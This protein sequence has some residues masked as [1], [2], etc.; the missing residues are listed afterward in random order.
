[1]H[2]HS[3]GKLAAI[4]ALPEVYQ[5]VGVVEPDA[6]RRKNVSGVKF[7]SEEALLNTQDLQAVAIE[8]R[9]RDLVPTAARVVASGRHI[10]LDKPAGP[11]LSAFRKLVADAR[12]QKLTIQMGYMLRYNPAF[13]FMFRAVREGWFGE[14]M[15]IDAM[16]G[17]FAGPG[18]RQE[19]AEY[20]GGGF[21]ELACH[22]L[23]SAL[24]I[25][26]KP[27]KV[28]GINRRTREGK[29]RGDTFADNQLAV[30]E[31]SKGTACLRCNHND[32]FGGPRRR[33]NIAGTR[34]GME[35]RPLESGKFVLTLDRER[36]KYQKG[37]QTV[38]LKGGRSYEAEF[39]DLARVIRG[40]DPLAWNHEHDLV[41][42]ETLLRICG[43]PLN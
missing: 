30:L 27:Q 15:E 37:T 43:M 26:G 41:V 39:V 32:P 11:S 29:G 18:M 7:I 6:A 4:R 25:M 42:H 35:I 38:Q 24:F 14:V 34:G 2:A 28:H 40:G 16:M 13:Q 17:K 33:F 22:I 3:R 12:E 21:F 9:I 5:L 19:L 20:T 36:G 31:F 8:T 10:H 23:D 1:M